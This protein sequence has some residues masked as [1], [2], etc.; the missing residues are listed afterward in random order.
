MDPNQKEIDPNQIKIEHLPQSKTLE[1]FS[2]RSTIPN[3]IPQAIQNVVLRSTYDP[4]NSSKAALRLTHD[5]RRTVPTPLQDRHMISAER[6]VML[7][8]STHD[9]TPNLESSDTLIAPSEGILARLSPRDQCTK[10]RVNH[11]QCD[12]NQTI[13]EIKQGINDLTSFGNLP[14]SS[15]QKG[16]DSY[17][18]N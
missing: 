3:L 1:Q 18:N 15:R 14:T 2:K 12:T 9:P 5:L 13:K 17:S 16:E 6:T 10:H 8:E 4:T 11:K 7:L